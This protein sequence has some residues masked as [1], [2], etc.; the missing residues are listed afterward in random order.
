MKG[1]FNVPIGTK[2]KVAF[3]GEFLADLSNVLKGVELAE[4]DF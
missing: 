4:M 3:P 2:T 1:E